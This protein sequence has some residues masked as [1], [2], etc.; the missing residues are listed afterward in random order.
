MVLDNVVG[1][2]GGGRGDTGG[3]TVM[4]T[5]VCG[6]KLA[7]LA[8]CKKAKPC[9]THQHVTCV[10]CKQTA[11]RECDH[12]GGLVCGAP[13]YW[14]NITHN[15]GKMAQAVGCYVACWRPEEISLDCRASDI[16]ASLTK[17]IADMEARPEHYTQ[18][19]SPNGWGTYENFLPWLK[20]YEFACRLN[21]TAKV[22]VS[23]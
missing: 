21:P 6:F 8:D 17:A 15:L 10:A 23:R 4:A 22:R 12:T 20:R 5:E 18:F 16:R 13:L 3:S 11:T 14:D 9:A 2:G 1:G 19:N 7:W